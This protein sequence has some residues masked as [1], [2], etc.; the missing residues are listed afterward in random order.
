MR[1]HGALLAAFGLSCPSNTF[2]CPTA[3][4]GRRH[5]RSYWDCP[6]GG[7]WMKGNC[8]TFYGNLREDLKEA[9]LP[10]AGVHIFRHSVAKPRRGAGLVEQARPRQGLDKSPQAER[11]CVPDAG[12]DPAQ[13]DIEHLCR[14]WAEVGR[15]IL[16][17]RQQ[18]NEQEDLT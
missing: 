8:R 18:I 14:V 2:T 9:V 5:C 17:R 4:R 12:T 3:R 15:A 6:S 11:K 1:D 10:P 16:T 7:A 13:G